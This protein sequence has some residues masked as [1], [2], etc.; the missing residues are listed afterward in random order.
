MAELDPRE[1]N[2]AQWDEVA[3]NWARAAEEEEKGASADAARWMLE[4]AELQAGERVLELAC[5]AG[6]VGP[7]LRLLRGDGRRRPAAGRPPR[8]TQRRRP[9]PQRRRHRPRRGALRHRPLPLRLHADAGPRPG[10]AG[11]RPRP[12]PRRP[13]RPRRLGRGREEPLAGGDP[14]SG[15]VPPGCP[16]A[17]AGRPGPVLPRRPGASAR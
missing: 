8:D 5:G 17:E 10:A 7:L 2:P 16:A 3:E 15:D 12:A 13:P 11:K 1:M 4:A 14:E 9:R 6:R